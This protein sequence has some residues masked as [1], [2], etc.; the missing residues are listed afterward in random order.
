[1]RY[2]FRTICVLA[3][4]SLPGCVE[5]L[6]GG[7]NA[8]RAA[9]QVPVL[10]E[11]DYLTES[12]V[13]PGTEGEGET[14]LDSALYWSEKYAEAVEKLANFQQENHMLTENNRR[15]VEQIAKLKQEVAQFQK[16]LDESN[17]M[18]LAMK[19]QLA[20]WR[21]NV[22]GYR[23]EIRQAQQTQLILLRRVLKVLG[24]ETGEEGEQLAAGT[25]PPKGAIP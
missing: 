16:E 1:M 2:L 22:L 10:P 4:I 7:V 8:R 12:T 24:A 20:K 9:D 11:A 3:V 5:D 17:E 15:Q 21:T 19:D 25:A 18:L 6:R 13:N 23:D 14:A